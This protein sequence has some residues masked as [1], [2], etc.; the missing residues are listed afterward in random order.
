[1]HTVLDRAV[2]PVDVQA[3]VLARAGGNPLYAE[4][5]A[6]LVLEHGGVADGELPVPDSLQG[7]ISARLDALTR[8]EKRML[9]DAAVLG[10]VFWRG[11]LID[12]N[13]DGDRGR[14][15]AA[16]ARTEGVRAP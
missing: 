6:R 4:E 3:A 16:E 11:A 7:L 9:Q 2:L 13:G 5:F 15:H 1:M 10:K 12:P 14:R 8:A